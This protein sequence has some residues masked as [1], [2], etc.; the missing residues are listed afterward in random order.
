[1]RFALVDVFAERP[2]TGNQLAVIRD[3][4]G[5]DSATMQTL[6]R[7][8]DFS[9]TT[10]VLDEGA[11]S[12]TVRIFTPAEEM[13][14]AGHPTLG[15]AYVLREGSDAY[16][17]S[18]R[19]GE[20]PVRFEGHLAW[21]RPPTPEIGAG[22]D[23]ALAAR[24]VG[25][26]ARELASGLEPCRLYSGA[27]YFL[28]PLAS[29]EALARVRV[30]AALLAAEGLDGSVFAV[31]RGAHSADADFAARMHFFDGTR[32]REDPAT[33]SA[34]SAFGAYLGM[35]GERG[36]RVVEQGFELGRPSR[37][38]LEIGATLEVGGKVQPV[39]AGTLHRSP[40]G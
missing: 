35:L 32:M 14:F 24:I 33:G 2:Y 10:F 15:T 18:L 21:M 27:P 26:D 29:L 28:V 5:L 19:A 36:R 38:Y 11:E 7:E 16:T 12:A 20:V 3:A 40:A 13:P 39:A 8:M 34:N 25:L 17:L 31:C 1:M 6:A 30:D 23:R 4:G 22:L 9:E 37:V